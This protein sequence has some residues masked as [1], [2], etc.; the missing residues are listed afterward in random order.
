M[1]MEKYQID[2]DKTYAR[3]ICREYAPAVKRA[4]AEYADRLFYISKKFVNTV[5]Y[6]NCWIYETHSGAKVQIDDEV[7]D[8]YVWL[9]KQLLLK[10]CKYSGDKGASLSTYLIAVLNST[11]T[12]NDWLK[13]KYGDTSYIPKCIR[14]LPEEY[15]DIFKKMK[16][17]LGNEQIA[18]MLELDLAEVNDKIREIY[19]ILEKNNK[20]YMVQKP[21]YETLKHDEESHSSADP[22]LFSEVSSVKE[23]VL[24]AINSLKKNDKRLLLLMWA[25][26]AKL[27]ARQIVL[28][29]QQDPESMELRDCKISK[30]SDMYNYLNKIIKEIEDYVKANYK[31]FYMNHKLDTGKCKELTKLYLENF[32]E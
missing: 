5:D 30:E 19:R 23:I 7:M 29:I 25:G 18:F 6:E 20:S 26:T 21:I 14:E 31:D 24:E 9:L 17:Q 16:Q 22:V 13:W 27:S 15:W 4:H 12:F 3:D 8:T 11:F 1:I 2:D 10:S 32:Y 28:L